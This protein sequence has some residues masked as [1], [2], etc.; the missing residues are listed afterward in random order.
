MRKTIFL[1]I[2]FLALP[3]ALVAQQLDLTL[4]SSATASSAAAQSAKQGKAITDLNLFEKATPSLVLP[5]GTFSELSGTAWVKGAYD[6]LGLTDNLTYGID[7]LRFETSIKKPQEGLDAMVFDIGR[8]AFNDPSGNVM[9]TPADGLGFT[10]KY[11]FAEVALRSG[12]TGFLFR[13]QSLVSMSIADQAKAATTSGLFGAQRLIM[14]ADLLLPKVF[15]QAITLSCFGQDDL[16]S[17]SSLI[18]EGSTTYVTDKGGKVSTQYFELY[19][20]GPV[21]SLYYDAFFVYGMGRTLGWV[22]DS[23]STSGYSYKYLPIASYAGGLGVSMPVTLPIANPN[24]DLR[25]ILA[26]GDK[27]ATSSTEGY[28]AGSSGSTSYT[29]FT[30]INSP[31]LGVVY[32]P[33]LGNVALGEASLSGTPSFGS[34]KF[35][36]LFKV[37]SFFRTSSGAISVA[38]I[39]PESTSPYLGTE[40]DLSGSYGI[41]SDVGLSCLVG[42]FV[43]GTAFDSAYKRLQYYFNLTMTVKL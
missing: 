32:S 10:F 34:F 11:P 16:T 17:S 30:P 40:A 26:S 20:T 22:A 42:L 31:T 14:E 27:N 36:G 39:N 6:S 12:Y 19:A 18:A 4:D 43:P 3:L 21:S 13:T 28:I 7:K 9:A 15:G 2:A 41:L 25:V 29:Y 8:M 24:L 23:A 38:G 37:I 5:I 35:D 1:L 33:S